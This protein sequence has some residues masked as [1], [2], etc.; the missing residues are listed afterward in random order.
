M[1]IQEH[2][3]AAA[4]II[5]SNATMG[6]HGVIEFAPETLNK[7]LEGSTVTPEMFQTVHEQ[8]DVILAAQGLAVG[9][10]GLDNFTKNADLKQV[11]A[12]M[13]I[14]NDAINSV[15]YR[16]RSLPTGEGGTRMASGVL[17][18]NYKVAGT[19]GTKDP[20]KGVK[21]HLNE[22]AKRILSK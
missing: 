20:L 2:V 6:D 17:A 11:S 18:M 12:T 7:V 8:R 1:A 5:K 19:S 13:K 21:Q 4:E 10:M 3:R 9:E 15:Y 14:G 22:E 16:E